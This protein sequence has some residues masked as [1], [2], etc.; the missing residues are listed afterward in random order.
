M[1][2]YDLPEDPLTRG[3]F[4]TRCAHYAEHRLANAGAVVPP[5]YQAS[6]FLYPDA[7]AFERRSLP[8]SPYF[9]YTRRGNPTTAVLEAKLANL[10]QGEWARCFASGMGAVTCA[11]GGCLEAGSH[12][13]AVGNCYPP[14]HEYLN[15]YLARFGVK[16]TFV[17]GAQTD[18]FLAALRDNT[19]LVY[20]ESPTWG[21]LDVL[22]VSAIAAAAHERGAR[23]VFDNSW[24]TPYFQNPLELGADLVIHSATKYLGGHSDTLGGVIVGRDGELARRVN[25]EGELLGATLDPFAA[26]L[27]LRSLRTLG[28]R[29]EQHQAS[30]LEVAKVLVEHPKVRKVYYP[31]LE[32]HP[33]HAIGRQQMRGCAGVF[34]F[35]LHDQTREAAHRFINRLRVFSI[36]CSWGGFDSLAIDGTFFDRE[37]AEPKW[38]IRLHVGLETTTDLVADVRQALED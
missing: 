10:E 27:L 16:T 31:A 32:S 19:R 36:G 1:D 11:V 33:N 6:T 20:L 26:W 30:A 8:T 15:Q 5:L 2:G 38:L 22:D 23:V 3:G 12:V 9:D 7:E 4:E 29:M 35:A 37:P 21:R 25:R 13:V 18:A 24:A 17:Y 14:T 34:N 28:L